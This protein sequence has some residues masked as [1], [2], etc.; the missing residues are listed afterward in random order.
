MKFQLKFTI[1]ICN[2]SDGEEGSDNGVP[3]TSSGVEGGDCT[4]EAI[5]LFTSPSAVKPMY[6]TAEW[7]HPRTRDGRLAVF[8]VLPTRI[9]DMEDG[10]KAEL[11]TFDQLQ[12]SFSWSPALLNADG[13]MNA[14]FS[15]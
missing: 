15:F 14:F 2:D 9:I 6:S 4:K 8:I 13:I 5:S 12:L 10:I 7:R 3:N 11:V 1:N